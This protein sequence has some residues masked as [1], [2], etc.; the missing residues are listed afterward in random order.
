MH[1][2]RVRPTVLPPDARP[3]CS[4][5]PMSAAIGACL[6]RKTQALVRLARVR[7]NLRF[8][9]PRRHRMAGQNSR[10]DGILIQDGCGKVLRAPKSGRNG[11]NSS[12]RAARDRIR[13]CAHAASLLN[14][15]TSPKA[16]ACMDHLDYVK[17][18]CVW[19]RLFPRHPSSLKREAKPLAAHL[20]RTMV[21][22]H[23]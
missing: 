18:G 6:V 7:M 22:M 19:P 1:G 5:S 21:Q 9:T 14:Q 23:R 15:D 13:F 8:R 10:D 17:S 2:M 3:S 16:A 4:Y 12:A 11:H 20:A